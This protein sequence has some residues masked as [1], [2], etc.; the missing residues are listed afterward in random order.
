MGLLCVILLINCSLI[1]TFFVP[2]I[3]YHKYIRLSSGIE[4]EY[5]EWEIEERKLQLDE[6]KEKAIE[7]GESEGKTLPDYMIRMISDYEELIEIES[8]PVPTEK[9]P[10]IAVIGR[11]NTGKSTIFNRLTNSFKDGA[12]VDDVPGITR[13]A[14]YRGG[15]WDGY[16]FQVI[17]T[18][19]IIF[20]DT[21]DIFAEQITYQA[22]LAL[23][24]ATAAILVCDGQVGPTNL[25]HDL[26]DWLRKNCKVPLYLAINKCESQKLG[27][28]QAA[29]FWDIG[30]GEPYAV[31]GI[32]GN[33]IADLMEI[34]F[35]DDKFTRVTNVEKE[36]A[37]NIAFLGRPNVGK[38]S[39]FNCLLG[40]ERTIVSDV[41][42]TTRDAVDAML[43][44]NDNT[45][46]IIDTPGIRKRG[47]IQ[48][49]TEFFMINRAFKAIRRAEV[50]ILILDAVNGIVDQDRQLAERIHEEGR[51][52]VI[53]LNKWDLVEDKD[54]K[55]Y[56]KAVDN[57][58]ISLP[59]L[60]WAEI[61]LI[62]AKTGQRTEK[63]FSVVDR[64]AK[65]FSKRIST[66][67]LNEVVQDAAS[68]MAPPRVGSKAG[69]IYYAIQTAVAPPT[70]VIFVN[71]PGLF[72]ESYQRYLER[73]IR[74]NLDFQGTPI[75]MI[76]RGKS[77]RSVERIGKKG[78]DSK[79]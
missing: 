1:S 4:D 23:E 44:R 20:D 56:I 63:L 76:F 51:S 37:T 67:I 47:K 39:L 31:S 73:K 27:A 69:R 57:I 3:P 41:A 33:G 48:Y 19:G 55:T 66:A 26:A 61:V 59:L 71:S 14:S 75:K 9:L 22:L 2:T 25:D 16:S 68:W 62:S 34:I 28:I 29:E 18:G 50:V 70:F 46:K 5:L 53:A 8:D 72:T 36:N 64:A 54:D 17:D 43:Y 65:Q 11:P 12:I 13:D 52:C 7:E 78:F 15:E 30:M 60:R 58:R 77:L 74:D 45:Y 35:D 79:I 49:G 6:L 24:S 40:K 21:N 38:S 10:V 32:H 42:G